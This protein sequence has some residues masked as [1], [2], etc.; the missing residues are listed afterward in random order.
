MQYA[1]RSVAPPRR[2]L[3]LAVAFAVSIGGAGAALAQSNATG[4]IFGSATPGDVVHIENTDNGL[5]R[6]ITVDSGGRYRA[7]SLPIGTYTV[8]LMHNGTAVDSHKG[9]QT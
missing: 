6:D 8:T 2:K 5:R 3:A 1:N 9:V 7:N 4:A